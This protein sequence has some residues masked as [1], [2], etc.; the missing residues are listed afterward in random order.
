ME[1]EKGNMIKYVE[2]NLEGQQNENIHPWEWEVGGPSR[3]YQRIE[4]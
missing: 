4:R 1:G 3:K 2:R